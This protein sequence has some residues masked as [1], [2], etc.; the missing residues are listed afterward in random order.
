MRGEIPPC[1]VGTQLN[2]TNLFNALLGM[3]FCNWVLLCQLTMS[4]LIAKDVL[5]YSAREKIGIVLFMMAI[6]WNSTN[7]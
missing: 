6:D 5:G 4:G 2:V 7:R 1:L 3:R